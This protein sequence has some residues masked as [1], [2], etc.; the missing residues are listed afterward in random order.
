MLLVMLYSDS[1]VCLSSDTL[2]IAH[3]IYWRLLRKAHYVYV[4]EYLWQILEADTPLGTMTSIVDLYGLNFSV[5][6]QTE[7]LAFLKVFVKTMDQHFPQRSYKTLIINAPKW[8]NVMYKLLSPLMRETTKAKISIHAN[9]K[10][11]DQ[12]LKAQLG[13]EDAEKLLPRTCWTMHKKKKHRHGHGHGHHEEDDADI[14][15]P[16][17]L[18]DHPTSEFEAQLRNFV[19]PMIVVL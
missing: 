3:F 2:L 19:S 15:I 13:T 18:K 5:M 4:N 10:R 6:R 17:P 9:G 7:L 16:P 1:V 8:F 14:E 11:Q 12:A